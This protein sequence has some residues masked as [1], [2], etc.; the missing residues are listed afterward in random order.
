MGDNDTFSWRYLAVIIVICVMYIL[1]TAYKYS[2][3]NTSIVYSRINGEP[4]LINNAHQD[5]Q[6]AADNMAIVHESIIELLRHLKDK[7]V[8]PA[9]VNYEKVQFLLNKLS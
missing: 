2:T 7:Y 3:Y 9:D 4:Y 6:T 8:D 1:W 5:I